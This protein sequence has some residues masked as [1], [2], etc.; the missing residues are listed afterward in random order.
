MKFYDMIP[1]DYSL[2]AKQI[3]MTIEDSEY[4]FNSFS[5]DKFDVNRPVKVKVN[6]YFGEEQIE[7]DYVT[8]GNPQIVSEDFKQLVEEFDPN[9]AQFFETENVTCKT[10]KKYYVMHV[11][12]SIFC[13][14][15]KKSKIFEMP[16]GESI[17]IGIVDISKIGENN[18]I[19][20]LGEDTLK[21]YVSEDFYKE[22]KNRKLTGCIF[23]L[24]S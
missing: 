9:A 12:K 15:R 1:N 18:H 8:A 6:Y 23:S 19:F 16:Y 21:H 5:T 11:T 2:N 17:A 14:D 3:S 20:R 4:D 22:Y 13:L 24:R 10:K 7:E